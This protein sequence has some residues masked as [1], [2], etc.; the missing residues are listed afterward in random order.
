[1][2]AVKPRPS[3]RSLIFLSHAMPQTATFVLHVNSTDM[4]SLFRRMWTR[5]PNKRQPRGPYL[6]VQIPHLVPIIT[7]VL[8]VQW[9]RF[10]LQQSR[11]VQY[12]MTSNVTD[13]L[14]SLLHPLLLFGNEV[15]GTATPQPVELV[16]RHGM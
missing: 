13:L 9:N 2:V 5:E 7:N 4:A 14:R 16:G 11:N 1:M 8:R 10:L 6:D 3:T 15:E 12:K